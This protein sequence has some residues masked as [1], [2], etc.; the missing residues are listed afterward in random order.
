MQTAA[1]EWSM[2]IAGRRAHRSLDG[3]AP[4]TMF[5]TVSRPVMRSLPHHRF[6]IAS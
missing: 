3:M 4:V 1:A 2:S 6:E 5:E